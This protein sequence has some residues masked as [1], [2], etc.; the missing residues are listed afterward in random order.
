MSEDIWRRH[1][2]AQEIIKPNDPRGSAKKTS[3]HVGAKNKFHTRTFKVTNQDT[4]NDPT[5]R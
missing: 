1:K 5:D 4:A 2:R 3:G